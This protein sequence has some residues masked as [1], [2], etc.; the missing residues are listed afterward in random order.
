MTVLIPLSVFLVIVLGTIAIY[1]MF[2]SKDNAS[3]KRLQELVEDE[4]VTSPAN[5]GS[6]LASLADRIAEPINRIMPPSAS[7][8]GKMQKKLMY[9]GYRSPNAVRIYRSI[10]LFSLICIPILTV[11]TLS[12]LGKSIYGNSYLVI[13]ALFI[14]Y[15]LPRSVLDSKVGSRQLRIQ[16][17]MADALDLLVVT[18]EAGLGLNQALVK[19]GDELRDAHPDLCE[20]FDLLN[21]EIRLGRERN[22][23]LKNLADRTG[24]EDMRSLCS[25][26]IQADRFGT[27]IAKAVR[28][29]SDSLRVRRRQRAEQAAQLAAV[30]L[31]APL[32]IFLFPTLFIVILGPAGLQLLDNLFKK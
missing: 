1:L 3:D 5:S 29:Y 14:G 7:N 22:T 32:S 25:M 2:F 10:Q 30:K 26:L 9:A 28:I 27:S 12:L 15:I 18:V 11:L 17:G 13:I 31:L 16:W 20:E 8:A 24:V 23:A 4:I 6:D 19:I 21:S